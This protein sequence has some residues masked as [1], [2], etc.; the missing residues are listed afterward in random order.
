MKIT[1]TSDLTGIT[2]TWDL[3]ITK[4]QM[5]NYAAGMLLQ[6]AFPHLWDAEREFF[7]T[8]ITP[9]EWDEAFGGGEEE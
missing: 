2:R 3:E 1:R 4:E 5:E 7:K 8:G 6:D 9:E